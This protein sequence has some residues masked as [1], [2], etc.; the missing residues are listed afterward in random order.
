M[1]DRIRWSGRSHHC[2]TSFGVSAIRRV[3]PYR[4]NGHGDVDQT[5]VE[6]QQT[7]PR[8]GI[9]DS[10]GL[11][12]RQSHTRRPQTR[13]GRGP[14]DSATLKPKSTARPENTT[15]GYSFTTC[16]PEPFQ[17]P[18]MPLATEKTRWDHSSP[19]AFKCPA[20]TRIQKNYFGTLNIASRLPA[21][22]IV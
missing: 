18:V 4:I 14:L 9:L 5:A 8:K 3:S 20:K 13:K 10:L 19:I 1:C 17:E 16:P 7:D 6:A 15:Y 22:F 12:P 2:R 11:A 21:I